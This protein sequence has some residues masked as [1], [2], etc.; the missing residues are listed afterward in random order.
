MIGR[1]P[2]EAKI[3]KWKK[4][5]D[6]II[7]TSISA[8]IGGALGFYLDGFMRINPQIKTLEAK[9]NVLSRSIQEYRKEAEVSIDCITY[10]S[11]KGLEC[12]IGINDNVADHFISVT[13]NNPHKLKQG[14]KIYLLNE[15]E[16]DLCVYTKVA[17]VQIVHEVNNESSA[18]FFMNKKMLK[19]LGIEGNNL[20]KGV[21]ILHFKKSKD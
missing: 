14:D 20:S 5:R 6:I 15:N 4:W 12:K 3:H 10:S 17:F 8:V 7:S 13:P 9:I 19:R 11:V 21:F 2:K 18:E 1:N 16:S